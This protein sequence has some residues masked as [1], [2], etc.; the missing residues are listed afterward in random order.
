MVE[1]SIGMPVYNGERFIHK[2]LDSLLSQTFLDFELIISDNASIDNTRAICLEYAASD[3]RIR[4]VRQNENQGPLANFQFVLDEA[5]GEYFMWAAA[6][7]VW[8]PKFVEVLLPVSA[9]YQC[10]AYGFVQPIDAEDQKIMHPAN[11][12]KFDFTGGQFVRRLKYYLA[13]GFLGKANPIYGIFPTKILKEDG[14]SCLQSKMEGA[15]MIL[16]YDYLNRM[17]I[18]HAGRVFLYKRIHD[19]CCGSAQVPSDPG[20]F[21]RL[22]CFSKIAFQAPMVGQYMKKSNAVESVF[23]T[24][25]YPLCIAHILSYKI[26][27]YYKSGG[28][29]VEL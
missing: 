15:D 12:R 11:H 10:L 19:D 4:Y 28:K 6:D 23:L 24:V 22:M 26:W 3:S 25:F 7:D 13:P 16:L 14:L 21:E 20:V 17:E 27:F 8:D 1:L 9:E 5:V 2:A 29:Y 18:R